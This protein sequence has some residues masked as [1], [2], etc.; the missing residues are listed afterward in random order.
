MRDLLNLEVAILDDSLD[1]KSTAVGLLNGHVDAGGEGRGEDLVL[2]L[3][4]LVLVAL[5]GESLIG[6]VIH[7]VLGKVVDVG[8]S[9]GNTDA[10]K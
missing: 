3:R 4:G 5:V 7:R 8:D 9:K 1:K 6:E 10:R 2:A